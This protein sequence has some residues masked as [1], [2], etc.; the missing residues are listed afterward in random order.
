M[1]PS[2]ISYKGFQEEF[3]LNAFDD[4]I[5]SQVRTLLNY[6]FLLDELINEKKDDQQAEKGEEEEKKEGEDKADAKADDKDEDKAATKEAD[7][8]FLS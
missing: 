4:F 2:L 1:H 3:I 7:I 8:D 6:Y 5:H